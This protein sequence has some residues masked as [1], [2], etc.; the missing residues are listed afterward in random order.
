VQADKCVQENN[1]EEATRWYQAAIP[2]L[3]EA[4]SIV[5]YSLELSNCYFERAYLDSAFDLLNQ[6]DSIEFLHPNDYYKARI[7]VELGVYF[8]KVGKLNQGKSKYE[9]ALNIYENGS[10]EKDFSSNG[11]YAKAC[12]NY[13]FVLNQIGIN[14]DKALDYAR[15]ASEIY[16]NSENY[17]GYFNA[18]NILATAYQR[19]NKFDSSLMYYNKCLTE[20]YELKD[21]SHIATTIGNLG[22]LYSYQ[23]LDRKAIE[24]FIQG[25]VWDS[26]Y[27]STSDFI[28]DLN[29]I[30]ATYID[31][32]EFDKGIEYIN[33]AID[34][35][36]S[37][38]DIEQQAFASV[39]LYRLLTNSGNFEQAELE[40][41][42]A[43]SLVEQV[44][45]KSLFITH[46]VN[47]GNNKERQQRYPEAETYFRLAVDTAM[48]YDI[49]DKQWNAQNNLGVN[50]YRQERYQEAFREYNL[51]R[52]LLDTIQDNS[53]E[54][55]IVELQSAYESELKNN[56][57]IDLDRKK[58]AA[59]LL[60][61]KRRNGLLVAFGIGLFLILGT[62]LLLRSRQKNLSLIKQL[63]TKNAEVESL[64]NN[65][66]ST[67]YELEGEKRKRRH[68]Q[69]KLNQSLNKITSGSIFAWVRSDDGVQMVLKRSGSGKKHTFHLRD[70]VYIENII[71]TNQAYF[72]TTFG[73]VYTKNFRVS[74]LDKLG[75]D[76]NPF[77]KDI[78]EAGF[79]R[80]NESMAVN[81]LHVVAMS[82]QKVK[83]HLSGILTRNDAVLN[84]KTEIDVNLSN[85]IWENLHRD[86][87]DLYFV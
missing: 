69:T 57:I 26:L 25:A 50:L 76:Q 43:D 22:A 35:A 5:K 13:G 82:Q 34:M 73:S 37:I 41:L 6:L 85:N 9:E 45:S 63:N 74:F 44:G 14:N 47:R 18:L 79:R 31:L 84:L 30:G 78:F 56:Q 36:K 65:L 33:R 66:S 16:Y 46:I 42:R 1:W 61:V 11:H 23:G 27:G 59:E 28:V 38:G 58:K 68:F 19:Q 4:D 86:W 39:N 67:I 21:S 80:V 87:N 15:Q 71:G 48:F 62:A 55:K 77:T 53:Q 17:P 20:S 49:K 54:A 72:Y 40:G 60:A 52:N 81:L 83:L 7:A 29:N 10:F 70:V 64:N 3:T 51:A 32:K 24:Y 75:A 8:V 12:E 2:Q